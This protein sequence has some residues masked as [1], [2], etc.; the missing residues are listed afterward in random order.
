MNNSLSVKERSLYF[1]GDFPA[2]VT[3]YGSRRTKADAAVYLEK[4]RGQ[5]SAATNP[6]GRA[7]FL[8]G[9]AL[10]A[11]IIDRLPEADSQP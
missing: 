8:C 9:A 2:M 10:L 1:G 6:S 4:I 5:A 11:A 7:T 3:Q